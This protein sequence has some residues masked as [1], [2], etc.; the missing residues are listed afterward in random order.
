MSNNIICQQQQ[1]EEQKKKTSRHLTL[2]QKQ[3]HED[4]EQQKQISQHSTLNKIQR[5]FNNDLLDSTYSDDV[6][7]NN[8]NNNNTTIST[9]NKNNKNKKAK[10]K[11]KVG[12]KNR[13]YPRN[14]PYKFNKS[15]KKKVCARYT[16]F[17]ERKIMRRLRRILKKKAKILRCKKKINS[18]ST[19][20]HN[21]TDNKNFTT[22][23]HYHHHHHD[24]T[25]RML[26]SSLGGNEINKKNK[27]PSLRDNAKTKRNGPITTRVSKPE[28]ISAQDAFR[29]EPII[30]KRGYQSCPMTSDELLV[31]D[32]L[33]VG[34]EV[35]P[36]EI[37]VQAHYS[38]CSNKGDLNSN[39][40]TRTMCRECNYI[41][42]LPLRYVYIINITSKRVGVFNP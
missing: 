41:V 6:E 30:T 29:K 34:G 32:N 2:N 5:E 17:R 38:G 28:P 13:L 23:E 35:S 14:R 40:N 21:H 15:A 39:T 11:K 36:W 26:K 16:L 12:K 31:R 18:T 24:D 7:I 33:Q 19:P 4:E 37:C 3:Q 27:V 1:H 22:S 20:S 9:G 10:G 25:V 8:N 42:Y